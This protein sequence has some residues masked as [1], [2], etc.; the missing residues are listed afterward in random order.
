MASTKGV[1]MP[2]AEAMRRFWVTARIWRPSGVRL[3]INS[4]M[5]KTISAKITIQ[6]RL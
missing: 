5:K 3:R 4:S 1:R 2:M 6:K